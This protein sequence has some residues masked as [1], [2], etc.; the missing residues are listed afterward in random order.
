MSLVRLVNAFFAQAK[1][2]MSFLIFSS[3]LGVLRVVSAIIEMYH[4]PFMVVLS[5]IFT[6][7]LI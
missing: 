3:V 6:I 5:F 4:R 7:D 1:N 2:F